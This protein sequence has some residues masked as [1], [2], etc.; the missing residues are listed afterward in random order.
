[1]PSVPVA[2]CEDIIP[3]GV[4]IGDQR[5]EICRNLAGI[6]DDL[7]GERSIRWSRLKQMQRRAGKHVAD[8][9]GVARDLNAVERDDRRLGILQLIGEVS[10]FV[11]DPEP[12]EDVIAGHRRCRN[13]GAVLQPG[14]DQFI[15]CRHLTI[16]A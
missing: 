5:L 11:R 10:G 1:M 9:V 14:Q 3:V 7:N 16:D 12:G 4:V 6:V 13:V 8:I 2:C 15:E